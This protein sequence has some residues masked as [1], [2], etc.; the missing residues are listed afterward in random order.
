MPFNYYPRHEILFPDSHTV[1]MEDINRRMEKK[2][3]D[4]D[5]NFV[6]K[7]LDPVLS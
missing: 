5:W 4:C 1:V 3:R 7:F 6:D 2:I